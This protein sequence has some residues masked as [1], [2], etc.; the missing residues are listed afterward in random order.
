MRLTA[1][2]TPGL[3]V[4]AAAFEWMVAPSAAPR[5]PSAPA[6]ITLAVTGRANANASL[7]TSGSFAVVVWSASAKEGATD[8]VAAV[9][10]DSGGTQHG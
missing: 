4:L 2:I 8:V 6:A 10:R 1:A 7:A 5:S 3:V 9:S